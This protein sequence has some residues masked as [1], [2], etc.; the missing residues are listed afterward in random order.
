M[1]RV[2]FMGTPEFAV[3]ALRRLLESYQVVG[4]VTQPDRPAGRGQKVQV[5][6]VKEL[7][8][9][10]GLPVL[11]P[12]SLRKDPLAVQAIADLH[13]D[14]IV[15]AAYGLILPQPV[16]D[17]PPHGCLNIHASLLPRWRGPAPIPAAILAGDQETGVTL[18]C[19]DAGM[20][21]GPIV[22]QRR[23][24]IRPDDTTA[25]LSERLSELGANLL[26]E[27]LPSWLNG[28]IAPQPQDEAQATVCGLIRKEDGQ[29]DWTRP[30]ALIERQVRAY[31]PWPG[32]FTFWRG[33]QLK[34]LR[35]SATGLHARPADLSPGT[36]ILVG[37]TPGVITGEGVLLLDEVQLAGK[38]A[39]PAQAFVQ[40]Y[41][42]FVG[43]RLGETPTPTP[44]ER[45]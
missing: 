35:S 7:A 25:S 3:P 43:S 15:V 5:S 21:T 20:D 18:M 40:G 8:L 1:T 34:V 14:L 41:R 33:Q 19:M 32:A 27:T 44:L 13:P 26:A 36:V 45:G 17:L 28:E 24:P 22:V 6:P 9:A 39:M 2:V 37:R 38:R 4:V 31:H 16:L 42:D 10:H 11:Q 12:R 30:A 29:I 23:T